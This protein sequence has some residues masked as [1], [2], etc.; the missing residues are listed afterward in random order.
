VSSQEQTEGHSLDAQTNHI[1][2]FVQSQGWNLIQLYTDAGISAKKGSRRPAFEQMIRDARKGSFFAKI[3][4]NQKGYMLQW[5]Y[6]ACLDLNWLAGMNFYQSRKKAP[7]TYPRRSLG[8]RKRFSR[9]ATNC[10]VSP[11]SGWCEQL[12]HGIK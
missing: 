2:N 10:S 7:P 11:H 8:T 1:Q 9:A 4:C 5:H 3:T 6:L 12:R